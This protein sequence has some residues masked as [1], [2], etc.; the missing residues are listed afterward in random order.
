MIPWKFNNPYPLKGTWSLEESE[1]LC[2]RFAASHY[3]NFPVVGGIAGKGARRTLAAVYCFARVADDFADE[4]CFGGIGLELLYEWKRQLELCLQGEKVQHPVFVA[5]SAA[6]DRHALDAGPFFDLL[7]AFMQDCKK[8]RYATL[9]EVLDYCRRSASPVGRIVLRVMKKDSPR[10]VALSDDTCSALQLANF[11]QDLSV[12][13]VRDRLYIPEEMASGYGVSPDRIMDGNPEHGF[14]PL[15]AELVFRTRELMLSAAD[16]PDVVGFPGELYLRAVQM[17][18]LG[19]LRSV[20]KIGRDILLRRPSLTTYD[21]AVIFARSAKE[22]AASRITR[23]ASNGAFN[24]R[25]G[26]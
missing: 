21:M 5:L 7:S 16:L 19:V 17:G 26:L 8:N 9:G 10:A 1:R 11:W 13:R 2:M 4:P 22:T 12:D 15:M 3:E 18:G 25:A 14:E 6:I 24:G 23:A 20:E